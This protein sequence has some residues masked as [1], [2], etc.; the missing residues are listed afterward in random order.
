MGLELLKPYAHW[1]SNI[2]L[3]AL[4]VFIPKMQSDLSNSQELV[5][6]TTLQTMLTCRSCVIRHCGWHIVG[7]SLGGN[8]VDATA[9]T[10]AAIKPPS[11]RL[12]P[13]LFTFTHFLTTISLKLV[14]CSTSP[15]GAFCLQHS[16]V[17]IP[18]NNQNSR[19]CESLETR[20]SHLS[21][22]NTTLTLLS[23]QIAPIHLCLA[24]LHQAL[25]T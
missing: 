3:E 13:I 18:Q 14:L 25:S 23:T 1:F 6:P 12:L 24:V 2:W 11:P 22:H 7:E 15:A 16:K 19:R 10:F 8:E 17:S 9:N 21:T 20:S 5:H 4:S